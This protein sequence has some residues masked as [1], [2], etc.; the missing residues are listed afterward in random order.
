MIFGNINLVNNLTI[1]RK[2]LK[3]KYLRLNKNTNRDVYSFETT[4]TDTS[5]VRN[6][7]GAISEIILNKILSKAGFE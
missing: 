7:F 3:R 1:S 4:A 5:L 2:F 6:I